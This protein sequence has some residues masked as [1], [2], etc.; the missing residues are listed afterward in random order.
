MVSDEA[1]VRSLL[2]LVHLLSRVKLR[3]GKLSTAKL[4][5]A[6]WNIGVIIRLNFQS[7]VK[8]RIC[9]LSLSRD[10][11]IFTLN[12]LRISHYCQTLSRC[13]L[14]LVEVRNRCVGILILIGCFFLHQIFELR[15]VVEL[16]RRNSTSH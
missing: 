15:S 6:A 9:D 8:L 11:G 2:H 13:I 1:L 16:V 4:I 10:M 14:N 12:K 3:C 7:L 5:L